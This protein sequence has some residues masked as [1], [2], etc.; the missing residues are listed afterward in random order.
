MADQCKDSPGGVLDVLQDTLVMGL[1][2]ADAEVHKSPERILQA[3]KSE[4]VKKAIEEALRAEGKRLLDEQGKRPL[5][6]ADGTAVVQKV[7][8]AVATAGKDEIVK[9]I[10]GSSG[11]KELEKKLEDL[12]CAFDKS[13][14]GVFVGQH[15]DKWYVYVIA[16][17]VAIG[18]AGVM[19]ATWWGDDL[20]DP[21]TKLAKDKLK[22]KVLGNV[23]FG[24]SKITFKPSKRETGIELFTTAKWKRVEVKLEMSVSQENGKLTGAGGTGTVILHLSDELTLTGSGS[25]GVGLVPPAKPGLPGGPLMP[26]YNLSVVLDY[27]GIGAD[28][29]IS[30]QVFGKL[31]QTPGG[32]L[33]G[34]VGGSATLA[35]KS[36]D[37]WKIDGKAGYNSPA[38]QANDAPLGGFFTLGVKKDLW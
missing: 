36:W 37:G 26:R 25:G 16:A 17:G 38:G 10:K 22:F 4:E 31:G 11:F 24:A 21:L 5:T 35:P 8:T 15:K 28:Q 6:V 2:F 23:E 29:G 3:L 1:E 34:G 30:F 32:P 7:G 12:K 20:A 18:G 19:Y 33:S 9:A 13:P 27:K 14:V